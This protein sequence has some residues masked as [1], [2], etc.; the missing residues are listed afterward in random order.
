MSAEAARPAI[1]IWPQ[2]QTAQAPST[3]SSDQA[4]LRGRPRPARDDLRDDLMAALLSREVA[5]AEAQ[6]ATR[7]LVTAWTG[8]SPAATSAWTQRSAT[9]GSRWP[10]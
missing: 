10:G 3:S 2:R 1:R 8:N 5:I 6:A 4:R 7:Q 9:A